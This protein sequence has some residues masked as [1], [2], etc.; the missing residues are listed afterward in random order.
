[1]RFLLC[2]LLSGCALQ[3]GQYLIARDVWVQDMPDFRFQKM[4]WNHVTGPDA[5]ERTARL[6]KDK[7]EAFMAKG[8]IACAY[9][10]KEPGLCLVYSIFS[11][12]RA[13]TMRDMSGEPL[14]THELRHCGVGMPSPGGWNHLRP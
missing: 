10:I 12:E 2:L 3:P 11:E 7:P 8:S 4:E 13:K 9:R 5:W 1:M 6:C 14:Y